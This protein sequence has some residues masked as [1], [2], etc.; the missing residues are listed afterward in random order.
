[1]ARSPESTP[2]QLANFSQA[3]AEELRARGV[4]QA[5][6][7]RALQDLLDDTFNASTVSNWVAGK[8]EPSRRQVAAIE[9]I[10]ELPAG[11]LTRHLGYLP[12]DAIPAVT[13]SDAIAI[14]P[15]L[16]PEQREDLAAQYAGMQTRAHARRQRQQPP[17]ER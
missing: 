15:T 14:D 12:V 16:T 10:L 11:A 5:E 1:M 8:H 3:L 4:A 13:T 6:L 2:E 17:A 9:Q 7:H